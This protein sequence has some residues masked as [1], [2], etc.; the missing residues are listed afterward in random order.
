MDSSSSEMIRVGSI[1]VVAHYVHS[2]MQVYKV[3]V[4]FHLILLDVQ[5]D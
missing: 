2:G 5:N 3:L 1:V 4:E